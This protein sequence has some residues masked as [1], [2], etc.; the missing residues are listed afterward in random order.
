NSNGLDP[1]EVPL[2]VMVPSTYEVSVYVEVG[3]RNKAE[4]V[5]FLAME[6]KSDS[7]TT[8]ESRVLANSSWF[9]TLCKKWV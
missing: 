2:H 3:I 4:V 9:V 8:N 6:V 1:C 7:I 5:V